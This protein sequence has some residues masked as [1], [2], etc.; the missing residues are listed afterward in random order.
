M[1]IIRDKDG[2]LINIGDWDDRKGKNPL[3]VGAVESDE[4]VDE[5]DGGYVL[6]DDYIK[7]RQLEYPSIPDQLD[8]IYH[9]GIDAWK[10][11]MIE[12]IKKKHKKK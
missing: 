10:A 4:E 1:K 5:I 11:D 6:K 8:Y 12:P 3:P 9:N 7:K 2:T